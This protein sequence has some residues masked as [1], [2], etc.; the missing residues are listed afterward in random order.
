ML[1]IKV[2]PPYT[3]LFRMSG[4][5]PEKI[6]KPYGRAAELGPYLSHR[7]FASH[8]L[9]TVSRILLPRVFSSLRFS[10]AILYIILFSFVSLSDDKPNWR[11][12]PFSNGK[13][14]ESN[15]ILSLN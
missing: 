3:R 2:K 10:D 14:E 8:P 11:D 5:K 1:R 4:S 12:F 7:T 9:V 6:K 13:N 15:I